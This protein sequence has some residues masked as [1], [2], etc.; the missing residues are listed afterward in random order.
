MTLIIQNKKD[1]NEFCLRSVTLIIS[2]IKYHTCAVNLSR[3]RVNSQQA[4]SYLSTH[5]S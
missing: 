3:T 5:K 4:N 2:L 1:E